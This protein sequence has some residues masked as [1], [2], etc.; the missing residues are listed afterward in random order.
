MAISYVKMIFFIRRS[1]LVHNDLS[2]ELLHSRLYRFGSHLTQGSKNAFFGLR[3]SF[4]T[5]PVFDRHQPGGES[6]VETID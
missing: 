3:N 1:S 6:E 2:L 4:A 5:E